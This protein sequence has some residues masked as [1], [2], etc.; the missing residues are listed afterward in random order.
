M[1]AGRYHPLETSRPGV[2]VRAR[3][4]QTAQTVWLREVTV[5]PEERRLAA[6]ERARGSRGVFHPSLIALFEVMDVP[7]NRMLLAYEF[8]PAQSIRQMSGGQPLHPKRAAEM[9]SEIADGVA[10][11]HARKL[12]HGAINLDTVLVTLKGKAKL[13]RLA[14]PSLGMPEGSDERADIGAIMTVLGELTRTAKGTPLILSRIVG[15][16]AVIPRSA[17]MLATS[18]RAVARRP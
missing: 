3:D 1:I 7:P 13:D 15:D 12:V 5:A 8:V 4:Q 11:L 2:P 17:A 6:L 18:L 16:R 14:D 9:M 10:E